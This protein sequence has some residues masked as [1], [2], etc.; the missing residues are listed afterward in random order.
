MSDTKDLVI[1][2]GRVQQY[3]GNDTV[4]TIPDGEKGIVNRA[5]FGCKEISSVT[6]PNSVTSIGDGA[7]WGCSKLTDVFFQEGFWGDIPDRCFSGCSRLRKIDIPEGITRIGKG[8]FSGCRN[9]ESITLPASLTSVYDDT[10]DG[11]DRLKDIH[12]SSVNRLMSI[13]VQT[14]SYGKGDMFPGRYDLSLH[15]K[16]W[17]ELTR[18]EGL[19]NRKFISFHVLNDPVKQIEIEAGTTEIKPAQFARN[20][21]LERVVIPDSITKIGARAFD[22]CASL[23]EITIPNAVTEIGDYAFSNCSSLTA[24]TIPDSVEN[25]GEE[26]LYAGKNLKQVFF[27]RVRTDFSDKW[28]DTEASTP[29]FPEDAFATRQKLPAEYCKAKLGLSE[30]E[31]AFLLLYQRGKSWQ[32]L[33]REKT[34][35]K[36]KSVF[37]C[38]TEQFGKDEKASADVLAEFL[39]SYARNLAAEQVKAGIE[40]LKQ[41]KYE[42]L[43][44]IKNNPEIKSIIS[45]ESVEEHPVEALVRKLTARYS[46]PK[47]VAG[48]VKKGIPYAGSDRLCSADAVTFILSEYVKEW[49]RCATTTKPNWQYNTTVEVLNDGSKVAVH[50]KADEVAA[51]LDRTA[52][53]E[54]CEKLWSG[55]K[56]RP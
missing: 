55:A 40:L 42:K 33:L 25:I 13:Y 35:K 7:F 32:T 28:F 39:V 30:K 38:L 9:L 14:N 43:K 45:G 16:Y 41:R 19:W 31:I 52:L 51:A 12:V 11:C 46:V 26:A 44:E 54:M 3:T 49:K 27:N 5:F 47:E 48:V 15:V 8:A 18:L 36:E 22:G 10:F 56:Y 21:D 50:E 1:E 20:G 53:S 34:A 6:I 24:I 17:E 23:T 2:N 37:N 29:V 4:I